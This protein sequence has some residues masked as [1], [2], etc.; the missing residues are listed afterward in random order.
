MALVSMPSLTQRITLIRLDES[1]SPDIMTSR[2]EIV[3]EPVPMAQPQDKIYVAV[4]KEIKECRM[5]L[6]WAL[7]N[8]G[9]KKI[10]LL[11]VLVPSQKIPMGNLI[12][13]LCAH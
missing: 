3:P 12:M 8:S 9:G 10:C 13:R 4:G 2:S 11:Y 6:I 1:E 7:R 5:T